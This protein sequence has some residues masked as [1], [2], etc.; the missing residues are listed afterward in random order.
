MVKP[1]AEVIAGRPVMWLEAPGRVAAPRAGKPRW[2]RSAWAR[3]NPTAVA[4][5]GFAGMCNGSFY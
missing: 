1:A 5:S 4:G 2:L 3:V